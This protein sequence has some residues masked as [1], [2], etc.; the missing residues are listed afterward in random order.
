MSPR[1]APDY[2]V[3]SSIVSTL[4]ASSGVTATATN[5]IYTEVP[6]GTPAPYVKVSASI[7][8]RRSDTLGRFGKQILMDVDC[9]SAGESQLLGIQMRDAV[10]RALDFGQNTQTLTEHR[11][12]G[13]QYDDDTYFPEMVNNVKHH[14]HVSSFRVWTE[15]SSS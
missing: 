10:S 3:V 9:V 5:G 14:H 2:F 11:L 13:L 4:R 8:G 7:A 12:L 1:R 6:Q 15:Q